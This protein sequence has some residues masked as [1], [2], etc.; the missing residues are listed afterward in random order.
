MTTEKM[1]RK[2]DNTKAAGLLAVDWLII[3]AA[4]AVA[5]YLQ[6]WAG[7][8]LAV[9]VVGNRQHAL[10]ILGHDAAHRIL[11]SNRKANDFFGA[12]LTFWPLSVTLSG[13]RDWHMVHHRYLGTPEDSEHMVKRGWTNLGPMPKHKLVFLFITDLMGLGAWEVIRQV[14]AIKPVNW[15]E[16][17]KWLALYLVAGVVM[18]VTGTLWIGAIWVV[19]LYTS[20]WAIVRFRSITEH[21]G[22]EKTIRFQPGFLLKHLFFPHN[23]WCHYEHHNKPFVPSYNLPLLRTLY[24]TDVPVLNVKQLFTYLENVPALPK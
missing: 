3:V 14:I 8:L 7:Y 6:H 12:L 16:H 13:Y 4:M 9:L 1:L 15:T 21:S 18:Y 23:T 22:P 20:L 11:F 19:S 17:L 5:G 2:I 10:A 24:N